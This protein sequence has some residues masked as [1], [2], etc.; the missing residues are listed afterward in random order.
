MG[1]LGSAVCI[2]RITT[3][4]GYVAKC[5][6]AVDTMKLELGEAGKSWIQLSSKSIFLRSR[7]EPP[8]KVAL[9]TDF[10]TEKADL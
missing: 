10:H 7:T 9:G 6:R 4:K 8:V 2:C 3:K 5:D 1:A